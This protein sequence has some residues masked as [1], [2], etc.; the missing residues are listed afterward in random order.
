MLPIP[1]F[2]VGMFCL[3]VFPTSDTDLSISSD[4]AADGYQAVLILH[5]TYADLS[6]ISGEVARYNNRTYATDRPQTRR[7]RLDDPTGKRRIIYVGSFSDLR[8][9][10]RYC[11]EL[12]EQ[13]PD[14]MREG[15]VQLIFPISDR[16]LGR[17]STTGLSRYLEAHYEQNLFIYTAAS[18]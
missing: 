15:L 5:D 9:A 16:D 17:L 11:T 3:A 18:R 4:P 10:T 2:F 6:E 8:S 1:F 7:F 13:R 12:V 14:F